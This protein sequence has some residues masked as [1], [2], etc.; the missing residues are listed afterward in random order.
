M[1]QLWGGLFGLVNQNF[2]VFLVIFPRRT[3]P[4]KFPF[5]IFP[6]NGHLGTH[7]LLVSTGGETGADPVLVED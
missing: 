5:F 4:L 3:S 1:L 6:S 2:W 7:T